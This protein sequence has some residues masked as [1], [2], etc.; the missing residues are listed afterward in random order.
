MS[1]KLHDRSGLEFATEAAVTFR[2]GSLAYTCWLMLWSV[3]VAVTVAVRRVASS[4]CF[5][6]SQHWGRVKI[7]RSGSARCSAVWFG[8]GGRARGAVGL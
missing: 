8:V 7:A 6:S 3:G 4:M 1:G 5:D 2:D